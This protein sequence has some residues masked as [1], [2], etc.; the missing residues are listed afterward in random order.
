MVGSLPVGESVGIVLVRWTLAALFIDQFFVNLHDKNYTQP[1]Y[2]RLISHY[3]NSAR[4]PAAWQSLERMV[5]HHAHL[6]AIAQAVGELALGVALAVGLI[7]PVVALVAAGLL[8]SLWLSE[9]GLGWIW[10]FPPIII[11]ALAVAVDNMRWFRRAATW[12][13][14]LTGPR[15]GPPLVSAAAAVAAVLI[16]AGF[17][18]AHHDPM[19]EAW[20]ATAVFA[21]SL[22]ISAALDRNRPVG[23]V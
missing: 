16:L 11:G 10:E 18:L 9:W 21:V 19:V 17:I 3:L 2:V 4:S 5:T 14:R 8:V 7:R 20:R 12:R 22:L 1:G 15:V 23:A 6:F 13:D